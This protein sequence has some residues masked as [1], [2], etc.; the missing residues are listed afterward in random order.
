VKPR[1]R[2]NSDS[3]GLFRARRSS[4]SDAAAVAA[5]ETPGCG[6]SKDTEAAALRGRRGGGGCGSK[7]AGT[8]EAKPAAAAGARPSRSC[9]QL[10]QTSEAV[11]CDSL[12][13]SSSGAS[14]ATCSPPALAMEGALFPPP[15]AGPCCSAGGAGE[16]CREEA[17]HSICAKM[18]EVIHGRKRQKVSHP[19]S[20]ASSI[21]A[22]EHSRK[23]A[24]SGGCA[25]SISLRPTR[26]DMGKES[27]PT[28]G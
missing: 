7:A 11:R 24:L 19:C 20:T 4:F 10:T 27:L 5:V 8:P 23:V 13:R 2:R 17:D 22:T 16:G 15:Q 28:L 12:P 6:S 3:A 26:L 25:V 21:Q 9:S 14:T 1:L 18:E